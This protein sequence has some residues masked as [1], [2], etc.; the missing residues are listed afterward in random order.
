MV[1]HTFHCLVKVTLLLRLLSANCQPRCPPPVHLSSLPWLV[2]VLPLVAPYSPPPVV[3]TT[4]C[5]ILLSSCH[6]T[7][8]SHCF[9]VPL[10][11]RTPPPLVRWCLQLIV[12]MPLVAWLPLFVLSTIHRLL[13]ANASPLVGLLFASWL[14]RHP[15]CCAAA[16]SCPLDMPPPPLVLSTRRLCLETSHLRL[17]TRRRLLSAGASLLVC[18]S[19]AGWFSH[20]I[21]YRRCLKCPSSTP[22]FIHTGWLLHLILLRCFRLPSSHQHHHLL[23]R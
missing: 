10:A 3:F 1:K 21:L 14:W 23:M 18:L 20:I 8:T 19:F 2:V 5:L 11:F 16:A 17:A 6:A 22:A 7:S 4:R 15:C 13:S 9:E 12:T